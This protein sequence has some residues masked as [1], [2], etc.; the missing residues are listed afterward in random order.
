[1]DEAV[2]VVIGVVSVLLAIAVLSQFAYFKSEDD[3]V[4]SI[5]VSLD[6]LQSMCR[7]TCGMPVDTY[8]STSAVVPSG[9]LLYSEGTSICAEYD[10]DTRCRVCPCELEEKTILNLTSEEAES[11]FHTKQ[12]NCFFLRDNFLDISCQG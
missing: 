11:F 7:R 9:A 3:K 10:G 1:M 4:Q 6:A 8:L 5:G 2:W 12:Y